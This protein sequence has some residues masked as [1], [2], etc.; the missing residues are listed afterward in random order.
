MRYFFRYE[1][2]HVLVRAGFAVEAIYGNYDR[3]H[4]GTTYPG[5]LIFVAR[6]RSCEGLNATGAASRERIQYSQ[7]WTPNPHGHVGNPPQR[8]FGRYMCVACAKT[9]SAASMRVSESVGCA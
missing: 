2:E 4:Y 3:E 9:I 5:E 8:L 1:M 7:L 6:K